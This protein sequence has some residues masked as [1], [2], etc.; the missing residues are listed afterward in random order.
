MKMLSLLS[1]ATLAALQSACAADAN[2]PK[3]APVAMTAPSPEATPPTLPPQAAPKA[4]KAVPAASPEST[5]MHKHRLV[6][7]TEQRHL[8]LSAASDE[9]LHQALVK[10]LGSEEEARQLEQ[11]ITQQLKMAEIEREKAMKIAEVQRIKAQKIA[12]V[13]M[14]RA[15]KELKRV[16]IELKAHSAELGKLRVMPPI[17]PHIEVPDIK[18]VD[19]IVDFIDQ[20]E[21]SDSDRQTIAKAL[22]RSKAAK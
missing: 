15:Q 2:T 19:V 16:Q 6:I 14:A 18:D 20:A 5:A 3:A 10:E 9:E 11:D 7:N 8:D 13:A 22:E 1:L 17:P 21:L 4:P 12:K